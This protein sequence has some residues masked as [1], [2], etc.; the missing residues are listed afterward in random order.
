MPGM[1]AKTWACTSVKSFLVSVLGW[2]KDL[3][4]ELVTSDALR[5]QMRNTYN[6][7]K[8]ITITK[9]ADTQPSLLRSRLALAHQRST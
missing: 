2:K 3:E 1:E 8:A 6:I 9:A 5:S 4:A 7:F